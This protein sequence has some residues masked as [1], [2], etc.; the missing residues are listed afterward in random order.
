MR[1]PEPWLSLCLV[2]RDHIMTRAEFVARQQRMKRI[3]NVIGWIWLVLFFAFLLGN[4]WLTRYIE[5]GRP[6]S[7][8]PHWYVFV[9]FGILIAN[10]VAIIALVRRAP[11][12]FGSLSALF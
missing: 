11:R 12:R 2:R 6:H 9:L 7:H 10:L 8:M 1:S 3:G 4:I 5:H